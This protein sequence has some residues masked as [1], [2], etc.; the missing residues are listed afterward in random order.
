MHRLGDSSEGQPELVGLYIELGN[1]YEPLPEDVLLAA[2]A[3][4]DTAL[5]GHSESEESHS[6]VEQS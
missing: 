4:L 5:K 1:F 3:L 6:R 2:R